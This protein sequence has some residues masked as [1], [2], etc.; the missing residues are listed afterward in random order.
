M[1]ELQT[2]YNS[3]IL[4]RVREGHPEG[5]SAFGARWIMLTVILGAGTLC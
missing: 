1:I 3:R 2:L 4:R 5:K